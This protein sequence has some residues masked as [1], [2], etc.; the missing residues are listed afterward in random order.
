MRPVN[1][2]NLRVAIGSKRPQIKIDLLHKSV[3]QDNIKLDSYDLDI[4]IGIGI[5]IK[6]EN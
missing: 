4:R 6:N 5:E 2:N 3:G 1:K